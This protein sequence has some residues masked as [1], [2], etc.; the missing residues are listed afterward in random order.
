M[1]R[2][3]AGQRSGSYHGLSLSALP[4]RWGAVLS[5]GLALWGCGSSTAPAPPP[6]PVATTPGPPASIYEENQNPGTGDWQITHP[7]SGEIEGF[8][9]SPSVAAGGAIDFMV[10]THSAQFNIQIFRLGWYGGMGGRAMTSARTV[11]AIA[12]PAPVVDA[13]TGLVECPWKSTYSLAVPEYWVSGIY[14]AKLT[15][16]DTNLEQYIPF[17]V[18]Y[19][20]STSKLLYNVP[21]FTAH[22]YNNWGGKSLYD[23]NSSNS[24][25]AYKVSLRRPYGTDWGAGQIL[26]YDI[27]DVRFLE[28]HGYDVTYETDLDLHSGAIDPTRHA[29]WI[30]M[31]HPEYWTRAMRNA[32]TQAR[33]AGTHLAFFSGNEMAW[34]VRLED[35]PITGAP[36]STIV[37]Y[38]SATLDPDAQDPSTV[39]LTTVMWREA[40]LNE[41]EE[42]VLGSS[43]EGV[44]TG[45]GVSDLVVADGSSWVFSGTGLAT[46]AHVSNLVGGEMNKHHVWGPP[47][48]TIVAH[49]PTQI[50]TDSNDFADMTWYQASSGATVFEAATM[51]LGW[52]LEPYM[53][54]H[55]L[56]DPVANAAVQQIV[57]NVLARF[58]AN[59]AS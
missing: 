39:N 37:C 31:A 52:G 12:Q 20:S 48:V 19:P 17:V 34:Q 3:I 50:A 47:G 51:H 24:Q 30:E 5:L 38:R 53:Q 26:D 11:N 40:P 13:E 59:P 2:Q 9:S 44:I 41:P 4:V 57:T 46:G 33:D 56:N 58:G 1:R 32:V 18:T 54:T 29:A 36:N 16:A 22:A 25:Q 27:D 6:A 42:M 55:S 45:S 21:F 7:A 8:A 49:S 10:N 14:L 35:S 28:K 43:Y 15:T 23:Y